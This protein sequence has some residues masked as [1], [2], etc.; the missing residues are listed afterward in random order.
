MVGQSRRCPLV[1]RH[2]SLVSFAK[3]HAVSFRKIACGVVLYGFVLV[4][5]GLVL[6]LYGFVLILYDFALIC[7][8]I[9]F[10]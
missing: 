9:T 5:Y 2:A 10:L 4:L 1:F 8:D 3:S 7:K 6:I